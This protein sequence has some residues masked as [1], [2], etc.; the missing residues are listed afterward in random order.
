MARARR[1]VPV[2]LDKAIDLTAGVIGRLLCPVDKQQ[3]FL[4]DAK[5]P[6]LRVRATVG[7]AKSFVFEAKLRRQT[8]R[9][10]IGDVRAWTIER[11]RMEANRLRVLVDAGQDPRELERREEGE[12]TVREA[13]V[14]AEAVTFGEAWTEY[15]AR[16]KPKKKAAWKP[17]Y[18]ADMQK[19]ALRGGEVK[20]RGNGLTLS[21]PVAPLLDMRLKDI[22][23]RALRAWHDQQAVR[24]APQAARAVQIVSG[25]LRWCSTEDAYEGF[26]DASAARDP[27]V[28]D[29]LPSASANRR[30]DALDEGQL[31][32][33]F[34]GIV[35]LPNRTAAAYL[36]GLLLTGAR[37]EELAALKWADTD[38][39][40]KKI[41]IADKVGDTRTLPLTPYLATILHALPHVE[42]NPFVFVSPSKTGRIVDPR[43]AH[44]TVLAHGGLGHVT[45]H[46]LRRT[47]AL[48]GEQAGCPA[49]AIAQVM[50]HR[51]GSMSE[52]YKPRTTD[53]LRP[54]LELLETFVLERARV[55]FIA[56]TQHGKLRAVA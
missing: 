13:A 39:R 47:F 9:R 22:T 19:M 43:S 44:A 45:L 52:R 4:R 18:L 14:K 35:H 55:T 34:E 27:K 1:D 11:A 37:R 21:G 10:T 38:F 42:G 33:W 2:E 8:I 5:A 6:G 48:M 54:Y 7:G 46:G 29:R 16:G 31:A 50:G 36:Q 3:V 25:F 40:W 28:Q 15:I 23:P 20:K 53:Q 12:R 41:T 56:G 26:V 32:A 17:R 51:P 30:T 49:G 24:G